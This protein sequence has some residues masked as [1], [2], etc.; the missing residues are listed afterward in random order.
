M[1]TKKSGF[2]MVEIL[3]V[4]VLVS[5]GLLPV[6]TMMRSGQKRI[7]R[8]DS[9]TIATLFGA[10]ALELARTLGYD[11]AQKL[12]KD[13]D[14]KELQRIAD[15]NGYQIAFDPVLQE[16]TPKPEDAESTYLLRIRIT[17]SAK[18]D[19]PQGNNKDVPVL[20]FVTILT[21]PRYNFY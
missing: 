15:K 1:M 13:E 17:V 14:F 8:A 20:T 5:C 21:D 9:R 16:I 10:S 3:L 18:N 19:K 12:A 11:R 7:A 2:T 6:Y 4:L